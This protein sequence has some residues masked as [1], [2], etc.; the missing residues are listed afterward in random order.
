MIACRQSFAIKKLAT[1]LAKQTAGTN[2]SRSI[3]GAFHALETSRIQIH[4]SCIHATHAMHHKWNEVVVYTYVHVAYMHASD[5]IA[6]HTYSYVS[7]H[8]LSF[9]WAERRS[10]KQTNHTH[11]PVPGSPAPLCTHTQKITHTNAHIMHTHTVNYAVSHTHWHN[12]CVCRSN[13]CT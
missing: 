4:I 10:Q 5:T 11:T 8:T 1:S 13:S 2:R 3:N 9:L 7:R 6:L 12:K